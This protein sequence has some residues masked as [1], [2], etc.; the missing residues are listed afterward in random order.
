[1][2]ANRFTALV[3]ACCLAGTLKRNLLRTLAEAD[4][5]GCASRS[6][7]TKRK[8]RSNAILVGRGVADAAGACAPRARRDAEISA[9]EEADVGDYQSMLC[10]CD[11]LPDP[12]D[13]HV[14]RRAEDARGDHRHR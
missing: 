5:F 3:D 8:E 12:G 13:A 10:A 14:C 6:H 2:F 11:T 1:M 4:F 9:F 7:S